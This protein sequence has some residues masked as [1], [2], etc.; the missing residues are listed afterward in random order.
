VKISKT[1]RWILTVGILA[2]LLV[3]VGVVYGHQAAEHSKLNS[4]VARANQ[5]LATFTRERSELEARLVQAKSELSTDQANFHKRS[6]SVEINEALF[7]VAERANVK[8]TSL[9]SSSPSSEKLNGVNYKVFSLSLS[10][11]GSNLS[12]LLNFTT[13][14][15]EEFP[16]SSIGSV[17]IGSGGTSLSLAM[18]V[19]AYG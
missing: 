8:L 2:I 1:V 14:L 12:A 11:E 10:V 19:Y 13:K 16:D 15:S 17:K 6:Q 18:K 7:E 9:R 3:G 4:D 5:N